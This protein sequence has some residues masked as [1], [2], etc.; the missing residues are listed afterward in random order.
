MTEKSKQGRETQVRVAK[1]SNFIF[2]L[3]YMFHSYA[4]YTATIKLDD[5][6]PQK[7][8]TSTRV[9]QVGFYGCGKNFFIS[10]Q[11]NHF[12]KLSI[13][14]KRNL[15]KIS[16]LSL[17]QML[18]STSFSFKSCQVTVSLA[19]TLFLEVTPEHT[20]FLNTDTML[21]LVPGMR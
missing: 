3:K 12:L 20:M 8:S 13:L 1:I 9:P 4:F 11:Q 7:K 16:F 17:D 10:F 6:C 21:I 5:K 18:F 14:S 15:A 2:I 19:Q